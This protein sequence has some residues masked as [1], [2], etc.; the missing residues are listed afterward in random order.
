MAFKLNISDKGKAWRLEME[1]EALV[2]KSIGDKI[3]GKEISAD[4]E[5]YELEI[6]GG[7]DLSGFPMSKDVQ[8]L[9]LKRALL[10]KGWGMHDSREGVR[11]RKT[12]RGKTVSSAVSLLNLKV[13]KS[14]AKSLSEIFPDQN[15][16]KEEKKA[17]AAPA[18]TA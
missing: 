14:G 8:G 4:L 7:S 6:M 9:G 11:I 17:E 3:N 12:L 16:P 18:P 13:V 5:G 2:G 15:K 1:S 10:T